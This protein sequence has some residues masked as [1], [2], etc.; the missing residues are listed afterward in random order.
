MIW[1][2]THLRTSL[3]DIIARMKD[4]NS[5]VE[6][7]LK[8]TH[9]YDNIQGGRKGKRQTVKAMVQRWRKAQAGRVVVTVGGTWKDYYKSV[10]FIPPYTPYPMAAADTHCA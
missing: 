4:L 2:N 8:S 7:V 6:S 9:A 10:Y 1:S 3:H 5:Y